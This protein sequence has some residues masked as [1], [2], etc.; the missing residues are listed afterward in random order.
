MEYISKKLKDRNSLEESPCSNNVYFQRY[1][2]WKLISDV[3]AGKKQIKTYFDWALVSNFT[4]QTRKIK[5][6][7]S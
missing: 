1:Q 7:Y 6:M 2:K 5:L 3:I 4:L